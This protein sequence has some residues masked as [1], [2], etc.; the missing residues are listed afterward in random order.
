MGRSHPGSEL[1]RRLGS[2]RASSSMAE[3]RTLN[4]QVSGSNPE[5]RTEDLISGTFCSTTS[6]GMGSIAAIC[7]AKSADSPVAV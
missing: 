2:R 1:H 5:G 6:S 4:P 7:A 3:Q